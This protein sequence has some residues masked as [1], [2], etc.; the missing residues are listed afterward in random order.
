MPTFRRLPSSLCAAL[1]ISASTASAQSNR[2]LG[3]RLD[4]IAGAGVREGRA[5]GM[6]AA[7]VKD[8]DTLLLQ[9]YGKANVEWDV[10]M[11]TD[12][13]FEVGSIA[14][15]FVA[16][17]ILQLK[18]AGKL[19]L[20][21]PIARWLP[22]LAPSGDNVTLR[23]L[24]SHTSGIFQFGEVQEWEI[25]LFNP[26]FPRDSA[27]RLIKLEP[28]QYPTGQAQ[29][30]NNSGFWLLGLVVEKAGG[31]KYEDYL[32]KRIFEPLG[33]TRSMYCDSFA[34]IP[35]RAHGYHML[36]LGLR[37]PP[38]V[39]YTLVSGPGAV[40]STAGDL[41][42]WLQA[43]HGGKVLSPES[44]AEMTTQAKLAD[45]TPLHYG[46]GIKVGE[47]VSGLR[48]IGHGGTAPGFRSDATWYPDARMAVVVLINTSPAPIGA[49][50]VGGELAR[51]VLAG[52]RQEFTYYTGDPAPFVGT[53]KSVMGGNRS[54]T[55][56]VTQSA[57]GLAFTPAGGRPQPLPWAGGLT[58]YA[59]E[60]VTLTFRRANGDSGPVTEL[61]RDDEGNHMI[62]RKQ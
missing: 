35:R 59:Q 58:F 61:R 43:L 28:L 41:V 40:C 27:Y 50:D 14:K 7:V 6:V 51:A 25:N 32:Q 55:I 8:H 20:E 1:L 42:T 45:G 18:D 36:P 16:A 5:V 56:E 17:S 22:D 2:P 11:T 12:A 21:E 52:P 60:T 4:S 37:R 53:Y 9:A 34:N 3:E 46:L 57:A 15:Q 10:P 31:M 49:G 39:N 48:R 54:I 47:D 62:L 29:A 13:M 33:M 44:Y 24:L 38:T 19:S 26:R 23:Q 30:Y